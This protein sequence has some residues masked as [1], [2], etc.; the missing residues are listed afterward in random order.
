V[1]ASA[2]IPTADIADPDDPVRARMEACW[3]VLDCP[4]AAPFADPDAERPSVLA[5]I[6]VDLAEQA[7]IGEP[8]V[9]A[10]WRLSVDGRK[11]RSASA[12]LDRRGRVLG[13]AE[14][15]WIEVR[16]R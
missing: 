6:T 3:S 9:L 12:L 16:P 1:F 13:L 11:Q 7:R 8:H 4:S 10:A 2:W 5:R 15:L 14:A